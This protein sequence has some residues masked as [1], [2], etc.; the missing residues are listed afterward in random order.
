MYGDGYG[1]CEWQSGTIFTD[2]FDHEHMDSGNWSAPTII[3]PNGPNTFPLQ[4]V[5]STTTGGWT[6]SQTFSSNAGEQILKIVMKLTNNSRLARNAY[7]ERYADIDANANAAHNYSLGEATSGLTLD[8]YGW[9]HGLE[10]H[11]LPNPY[12]GGLNVV[13]PNSG[14]ACHETVLS[15]PYFGDGALQLIWGS[16]S[17]LPGATKTVTVEYRAM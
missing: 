1:F 11:T 5:R 8:Y 7:L 14:G 6:L 10:I 15:D 2:Y 4:I 12:G 16:S 17:I 3:Q 9:G 13:R